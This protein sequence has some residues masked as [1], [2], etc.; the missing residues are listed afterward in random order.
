[1]GLTESTDYHGS[2]VPTFNVPE[3]SL[4]D[5]IKAAA[6]IDPEKDKTLKVMFRIG[7]NG[8]VH[9][10]P[11]TEKLRI[12]AEHV[13]RLMM[14]ETIIGPTMPEPQGA[15]LCFPP[16]LVPMWPLFEILKMSTLNLDVVLNETLR[17]MG[18]IKFPDPAFVHAMRDTTLVRQCLDWVI[19]D[20]KSWKSSFDPWVVL[21]ERERSDVGHKRRCII[22]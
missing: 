17:V 21:R 12:V 19:N 18:E 13:T 11:A 7:D 1:L 9:E 22:Y 3:L 10:M 14:R 4:G 8:Q 5:L 2:Q 15:P 16:N 6:A 20:C